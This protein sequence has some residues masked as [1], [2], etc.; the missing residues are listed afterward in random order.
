[1]QTII[2]TSRSINTLF[3]AC[4]AIVILPW[5][6][7][8]AVLFSGACSRSTPSSSV[9]VVLWYT[10]WVG[11]ACVD[12]NIS[13]HLQEPDKHLYSENVA[14][15]MKK[16]KGIKYESANYTVLEYS[17]CVKNNLEV[18]KVWYN[19]THYLMTPS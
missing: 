11:E 17:Q 1:M 6:E 4:S 18:F 15:E 10:G 16:K 14:G 19:L 3:W 7:Y 8:N 5:D 12:D 9:P 13:T 2:L